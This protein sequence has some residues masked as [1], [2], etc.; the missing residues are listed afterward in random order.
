MSELQLDIRHTLHWRRCWTC[1]RFWA[2]ESKERGDCPLCA[3]RRS[4]ERDAE[5]QRLGRR[6]IALRGV[7]TRLRKAR[8]R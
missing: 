4:R 3:E 6:I 8:K 2:C 1:S 7:I 5:E